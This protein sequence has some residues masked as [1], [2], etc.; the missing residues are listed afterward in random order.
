M[1]GAIPLFSLCT[2]FAWTGATTFCLDLQ[3][4]KSTCAVGALD[5]CSWNCMK[6]GVPLPRHFS[7]T[8]LRE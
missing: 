8:C 7:V 6:T 2:F 1:S 5:L 4:Y 3:D